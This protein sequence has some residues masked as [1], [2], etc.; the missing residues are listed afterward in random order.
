MEPVEEK[1][2]EAIEEKAEEAMEITDKRILDAIEKG[3]ESVC[4]E[5]GGTE[6]LHI[7]TYHKMEGTTDV[8]ICRDCYYKIAGRDVDW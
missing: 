7:V 2:V 5:C 6:E 4:K 3:L 1:D 8:G